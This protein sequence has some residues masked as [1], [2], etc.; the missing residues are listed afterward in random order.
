MENI[1]EKR[2]ISLMSGTSLDGLDIAYCHIKADSDFSRFGVKLIAAETV[3]YSSDWVRRLAHLDRGT[4]LEYALANVELGQ[5]FGQRVVD[6][7][8]RHEGDVDF[9]A[10]HGHTI[11]HQPERRLTAQIGDGNAIAAA[12]GLPVVSDFRALDVALGGQGAP[13]VPMGD[14][15]LF[16][17]YDG[18]LNLGG[19][20]NI[21]YEKDGR[22]V[23]FD[24]VPCNIALN[25]LA[26]MQGAIYDRDGLMA[27]RGEV[28]DSLFDVL[29]ALP[30]Y[31]RP[32]PKSLGKE[33]FVGEFMPLLSD[34]IGER[35]F[36]QLYNALRT[37]TEHIAFQVA[38][39]VSDADI[40]TLMVTGGGA[41]NRFLIQC[42][43]DLLPD[44][45]IE[46]PSTTMV[47]Y[48]EAI[49][50]A[51]LGF[52]RWH[53]QNNTLSSVTGAPVDSCGGVVSGLV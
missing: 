31:Q 10:S 23:A 25:Y 6:F 3:R 27:Q 52:M 45:E 28:I 14:Q 51:L 48:K 42:L 20:A 2:V 9:I 33:W 44:C 32:L 19:F 13:L 4:A 15:I 17:K 29:N 53:R 41:K 18:C 21:S 24:I 34:Y 12:T 26:R 11:F 5:F 37:V 8:R 16:R 35:T 22:R 46:I 47:D 7:R 39:A 49:V 1:I 30:Y 50:F 40:H 43:R 38:A 36:E